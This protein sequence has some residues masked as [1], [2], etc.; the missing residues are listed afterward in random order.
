MGLTNLEQLV[1]SIFKSFTTR[2][3]NGSVTTGASYVALNGDA[4]A[5]LVYISNTT[6]EVLYV[7]LDGKD[8][9]LPSNAIFPINNI[10][11]L[12]TVFVKTATGAVATITFRYE[13]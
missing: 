12:N 13:L 3:F 8:I 2:A 4:P 9:Y 7:R 11:N 5:R 1:Q 10:S 6:T